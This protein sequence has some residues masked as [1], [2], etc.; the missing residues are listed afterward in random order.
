[1]TPSGEVQDS[2]CLKTSD[3]TAVFPYYF[4]VGPKLEVLRTGTMMAHILP[5]LTLGSRLQDHLKLVL[6]EIPPSW[7]D[8]I[9][10][11]HQVCVLKH[12]ESDL[13]LRGQLVATGQEAI[14]FLV[15]P[16]LTSPDQLEKYGLRAG[17]LPQHDPAIQQFQLMLAQQSDITNARR[18]AATLKE[19]REELRKIN[20]RLIQQEQEH[21]KLAL[22]AAKTDNSVVIADCEGRIEW[23]NEAFE[24]MTGFTL[25]E[26]QGKKPGPL[27]QCEETDPKDIARI[28]EG[29]GQGQSFTAEILN[30]SKS[31]RNYWVEINFQPILDEHGNLQNYMAIERDVTKRKQDM[32]RMNRLTSELQAIFEL[33]PDGFVSFNEYGHRSYVNP[34]FLRIT[35]LSREELEN[36]SL[37]EFDRI[38]Q[39]RCDPNKPTLD[40]EDG[41]VM[42]FS[43]PKYTVVKRSIREAQDAQNN[44]L[45][46]VQYFRDITHETELERMKGQFLSM[47]A[48]E[49]RTP[50]ASIHG[51]TELLLKRNFDAPRQRDMLETIFRQS[52]RLIQ[53]INDLL[54]LA[55]IEARAGQAFDIKA[56]LLEPII[57]STVDA[58]IVDKKHRVDC[59]LP[60]K[61]PLVAVDHDKLTQALTNVLSNAY[62]Y[63]PDGGIVSIRSKHQTIRQRDYIGISVKDQGIGMTK[64]QVERVFDRF[65]RADTSGK[66]PGTGLGMCLVK[67]IMDVHGGSVEVDSEYGEGTEVTLWLPELNEAQKFSEI[68]MW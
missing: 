55:R 5:D 63:S 64:D 21:R 23:A 54:D 8:L 58:L 10:S 42:H 22:I 28:A 43:E 6:P 59:Q 2:Y 17:D 26:I 49:L 65:F 41:T 46:V 25:A 37:Q 36:V 1:M 50:M 31:G 34:A 45:G 13:L 4:A 14:L 66:I 30:R 57:R 62:K 29:L 33:S 51:F 32:D 39:K 11:Q 20:K 3:I 24:K 27:L 7:E 67:E 44:H 60:E 61:L 9:K 15:T 53:M 38:I 56:Q 52:S 68:T 16:W 35:G 18:M 12:K 40:T 47:A 19:Q 48:H